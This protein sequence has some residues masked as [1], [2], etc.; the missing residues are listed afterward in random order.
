MPGMGP[1]EHQIH[2]ITEQYD[3]SSEERPAFR[4]LQELKS[5]VH[6]R[7]GHDERDIDYRCVSR[8][9]GGRLTGCA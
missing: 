5:Q 8:V 9:R 2:D 7:H 4:D 3:T 6:D 1:A